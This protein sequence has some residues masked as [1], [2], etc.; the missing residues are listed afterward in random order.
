MEISHALMLAII[1]GITE[2]LPVSSSGHLAI[3][4][5]LFNLKENIG[6]DVL[7]HF[8]T[9]IVIFIVFFKDIISLG[10]NLTYVGYLIVGTIPIA[11]TGLL[12]EDYMQ[13]IFNNI[14]LVGIML[15]ITGCMLYISDIKRKTVKLSF[16]IA[17]LI[18]LFQ[19]FAILPG[20]S[21][22]GSTIV[23]ALLF[24]LSKSEAVF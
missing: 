12:L 19:A 8:A 24:G 1:Q 10:K 22:S 6:Y 20:I 9:L 18:G 11:I 23:A 4:Q 5:H 13:A 3:M 2:W 21:R 7:L 15:L 14:K 16:K 17:F